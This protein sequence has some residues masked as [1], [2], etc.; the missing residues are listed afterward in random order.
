MASDGSLVG[1]G[2]FHDF[3]K[4]KGSLFSQ[5]DELA[6]IVIDDFRD[7]SDSQQCRRL[8]NVALERGR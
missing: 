4:P 2:N 1:Y 7:I 8:I 6:K 3:D 5:L